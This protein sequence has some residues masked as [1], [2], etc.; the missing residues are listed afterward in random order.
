MRNPKFSAQG[1]QKMIEASKLVIAAFEIT[2]RRS[3]YPILGY[4]AH[5]L[6]A[7]ISQMVVGLVIIICMVQGRCEILI[8]EKTPHDFQER[9]EKN[10]WLKGGGLLQLHEQ[11]RFDEGT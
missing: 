10:T 1:F 7:D 3:E 5:A 4:E 9:R 8:K 6:S 11:S 2:S